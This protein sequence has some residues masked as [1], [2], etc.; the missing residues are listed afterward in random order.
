MPKNKNNHIAVIS[1]VSTSQ[2]MSFIWSFG[3]PQYTH[4]HAIR[5]QISI[6]HSWRKV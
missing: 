1:I 5:E 4:Y 6:C 2:V 3:I